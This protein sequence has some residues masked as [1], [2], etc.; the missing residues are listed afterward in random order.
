MI[1]PKRMMPT[2]S[3]ASLSNICALSAA[4]GPFT[5][6]WTSSPLPRNGHV[7]EPG[8]WLKVKHA[9]RARSEGWTGL[10]CSARYF[11]LAQTTCVRS[12]ILRATRVESLSG[13]TCNATSTLS[14]I[15]ST[16]RF[17]SARRQAG[18]GDVG[19]GGFNGA[20]N[21]AGTIE[22]NFSLGGQCEASRRA[23]DE[24]HTQTK[25]Q[26]RDELRDRGGRQAHV[27][28][29]AGKAA[30]LDHTL[31][32]AHFVGRTGHIREQVSRVK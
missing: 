30:A 20:K 32:N 1:S 6:T 17:A 28:R 29:C 5:C 12:T 13:P 14:A 10:P 27:F 3:I 2:P 15:R 22:I 9:C 23:I 11:G 18:R 21:V 19:L 24:P 26:S 8:M 16:N 4:T 31:E 25:L 7:V